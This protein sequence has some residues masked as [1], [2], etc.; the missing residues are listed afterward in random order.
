M[1]EGLTGKFDAIDSFAINS[2]GLFCLIGNMQEGS[3]EKGWFVHVPLNQSLNLSLQIDEIETI[4]LRGDQETYLV[5][6]TTCEWDLRNLLLGL[7]IG[8]EYLEVTSK[9]V[10]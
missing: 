7:N 8:L 3:I 5:L 2:R 4:T 6:I 10:D 1:K 9:P